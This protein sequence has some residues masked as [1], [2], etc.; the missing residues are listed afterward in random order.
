L[1]VYH[2]KYAQTRGWVKISAA[3][4]DKGAGKLIQKTLGEG[5]NLP[6]DGYAIFQ[7]YG[8]HQEYILSC[9]DLV[10]K[11]LY[12]EL[13]GYQ[14]QAFLDWRFVGGEQWKSVC[15][16]LNG[17]GVPSVQGKYEEMFVSKEATPSKTETN[18]YKKATR[19][20]A[21][22]KPS[23]KDGTKKAALDKDK[24]T[25]AGKKAATKGNRL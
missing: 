10:E 15:E 14:C 20:Q 4:M 8:T 12:V 3:T 23:G 13:D 22:R 5:L 25:T 19:K 17:A 7:D 18:K 2:N 21:A 11:G 9:R 16:T 24:K 1:V 6:H